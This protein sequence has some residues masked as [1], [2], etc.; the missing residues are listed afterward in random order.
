MILLK[1]E[2]NFAIAAATVPLVLK[3]N[4]YLNPML[5]CLL[6]TKNVDF[7]VNVIYYFLHDIHQESFE[8][9]ETDSSSDS[10]TDEINES[11]CYAGHNFIENIIEKLTN[12]CEEDLLI[13]V[14]QVVYINLAL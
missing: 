8:T 3:S 4:F 9:S 11:N 14:L 5:D 13:L 2:N 7:F 10:D 6:R 12:N 1:H